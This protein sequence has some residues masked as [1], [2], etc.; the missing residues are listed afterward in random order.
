MHFQSRLVNEPAGTAPESTGWHHGWG[1]PVREA[2]VGKEEEAA[3]SAEENKAL[4]RRFFEEVYNRG[5][6][7]LA[8]ELLASDFAWKLPGKDADIEDYKQW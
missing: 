1:R 7:D 6:L 5:N 3:V 8:D 2:G 4:V